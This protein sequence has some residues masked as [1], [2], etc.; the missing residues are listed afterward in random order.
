MLGGE[1]RVG[2]V[3]AA[4]EGKAAE[5]VG[6]GLGDAIRDRQI[7]WTSQLTTCAVLAQSKSTLRRDSRAFQRADQGHP[8][9]ASAATRWSSSRL[10]PS[11]ADWEIPCSTAPV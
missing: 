4:G 8:W 1:E 2:G 5:A 11:R 6:E 10:A 7:D 9:M 3:Q